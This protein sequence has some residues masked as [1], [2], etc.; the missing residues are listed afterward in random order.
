M[1]SHVCANLGIA[2]QSYN[3][4]MMDWDDERIDV[5]A[6][7]LANRLS[8]VTAATAVNRSFPLLKLSDQ[9]SAEYKRL[10]R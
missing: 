10:E 4:S 3:D 9:L 7:H 1:H 6:R 5:R 2:L 8:T